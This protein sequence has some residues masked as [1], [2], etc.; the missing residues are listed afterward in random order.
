VSTVIPVVPRTQP[1]AGCSFLA[2]CDCCGRA[3]F[4]H[5]HPLLL[6]EPSPD[7]PGVEY[8]YCGP[9][10][11][12]ETADRLAEAAQEASYAAD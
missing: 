10:G 5:D 4:E 7:F 9:C 3:L 8:L 2:Y 1:R 11:R 6:R 12:Q